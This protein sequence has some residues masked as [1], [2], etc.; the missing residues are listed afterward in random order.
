MELANISASQSYSLSCPSPGET[1][2]VPRLGH[3]FHFY[4]P[5]SAVLCF[6]FSM[7]FLFGISWFSVPFHSCLG[8]CLFGRFNTL[9]ESVIDLE[10]DSPSREGELK[11][12]WKIYLG[13]FNMWMG[14]ATKDNRCIFRKC[15]YVKGRG[16]MYIV[17]NM[18]HMVGIP[19]HTVCNNQGATRY[20]S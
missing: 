17:D 11:Q 2:Q 16:D 12:R 18:K 3:N 6:R 14:Q 8:S 15:G 10:F 19:L 9:D 1:A 4:S 7:D 13:R 5:L 20:P